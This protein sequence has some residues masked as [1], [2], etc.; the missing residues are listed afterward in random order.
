MFYRPGQSWSIVDYFLRP[1]LAYYTMKRELVDI[2]INTKRV[3]EEIPADKY[4][5]AHI[6]R[7]HKVQIFVTNLSLNDRHYLLNYQGWDITTGQKLFNEQPPRPQYLKHNQSTEICVREL[8]DSEIPSSMVFAAYLINPED[9][10]IVARSINWPEPLKYIHFPAPKNLRID[11]VP[12]QD[13]GN[14]VEVH[15]DIPVKGFVLEV[16]NSEKHP[17]V[18]DDNCVDLVPGEAIRI[19][20]QGLE[21]IEEPKITYRHLKAATD[22]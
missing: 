13:T 21:S 11:I 17:I 10:Q 12:S 20:V 19:A 6:K 2:T 15:C 1:K 16:E 3:V 18:F 8:G 22:L 5:H 4:T 9:G 14:V 7:I